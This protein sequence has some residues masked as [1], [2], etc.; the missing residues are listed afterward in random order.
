M[1]V[2]A[3]ILALA[4]QDI[5]GDMRANARIDNLARLLL[6]CGHPFR[7]RSALNIAHAPVCSLP[8]LRQ[9]P[10]RS[11]GQGALQTGVLAFSLRLPEM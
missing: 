4:C 5:W 8:P 7:R 2:N 3:E 11:V 1:P 6:V 9:A 10:P